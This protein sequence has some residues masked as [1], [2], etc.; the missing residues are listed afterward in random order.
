M[1]SNLEKKIANYLGVSVDY[2]KGKTNEMNETL[3][4]DEISLLKT[5]KQ[6]PSF[7]LIKEIRKMMK[8]K[9][10]KQLEIIATILE[11]D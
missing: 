10:P 9:S 3:T 7:S 11:L 5:Y 6:N 2:L 4:E 8:H 1:G